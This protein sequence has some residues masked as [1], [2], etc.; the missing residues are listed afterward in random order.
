MAKKQRLRNATN[1]TWSASGAISVDL[2]NKPQTITGL[3]L[4][5]RLNV[6]TSASITTFGDNYDRVI[7]NLT[8]SG[9]GH[10]FFNLTDMITP[11]HH[12]R[13][14][15]GGFAPKRPASIASGQTST[16][17]QFVYW[18]PFGVCPVVYDQATGKL[19]RNPWDLT[20][21]IPPQG[22][23]NLLLTGAWGAAAAQGTGFTINSGQVDV[24]YD[25]V[26]PEGG[27]PVEAW[28][29]RAFPAWTMDSPSLA[30]TS[31]AFA[32]SENVP[33]GHFAQFITAVT[34]D[35]SN[36]PRSNDVLNS[37]QLQDV[38]GGNTVIQYGG[39]AGANADYLAAELISQLGAGFPIADDPASPGTLTVGTYADQGIFHIDLSELANPAKGG[40]PL[41]GLD[42]R[43][44]G[45]GALAVQ[46]GISDAT[47]S[48]L[49]FL[50]KQYDLN[51]S[52]P[53]NAGM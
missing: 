31:G 20:G 12:F 5:V 47:G 36:T 10:T 6:T 35:G 2:S 4:D 33:V 51:G 34:R 42:L 43:K 13:R 48:S 11:Y 53:L 32:S 38:L 29:P 18:I 37:V 49:T 41:Y 17:I 22:N 28:S 46:Y 45:V 3:Y 25:G 30:A 26:L 39:Q 23:G 8:L 27:D 14:V 9:G 19:R 1:S 21:G 16:T 40:S 7:S 15:L 50:H 52:H 24:Y 44:V